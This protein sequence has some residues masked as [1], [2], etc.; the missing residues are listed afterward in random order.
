MHFKLRCKSPKR[1]PKQAQYLDFVRQAIPGTKV[2]AHFV[3]GR[4]C[5]KSTTLILTALRLGLQH[6]P[7]LPGII[8]EPVYPRLDD[9]IVREWQ[10]IV[11][12][13]LYKIN[14]SK[15]FITLI[16]GTIIDLRSRNVD[17]KSKEVS[18]GP[19]YAWALEDEQAYKCDLKK[20]DDVDAA[21]R[22]PK[23]PFLFHGSFST[24]KMNDYHKLCHREEALRIN[25]TSFD[26]PFLPANFAA[27]LESKLSAEYASQE[28][29]GEWISLTGRIWKHWDAVLNRCSDRFDYARPW[30]LWCDLGINSAWIA[31]QK[32]SSGKIVAHFEWTPSDEGAEQTLTRINATM[33]RPPK[34]V[35]VGHDINTRSIVDAQKPSVPFRRLWGSSPE[36]RP[37]TGFIADKQLQHMQG[38]ASICTTHGERMFLIADDFV[39]HDSDKGRGLIEL[40]E[41]DS[42]STTPRTG[43]F[44]PKDHRL[45]HMRDAWMYGII[46]NN[47]PRFNKSNQRAR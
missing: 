47:P 18:K 1:Y 7:G 28:I 16:N 23:A 4:G 13:E 3:G 39:S 37:V 32:N 24:P 29:Y 12:S 9:V 15:M 44:L 35:V 40:F 27:D 2:D 34:R 11:P 8:T 31:V 33:Q 5:A 36:I 30:E 20:W 42:W 6:C 25:A 38:S 41:Q 17:N 21:I 45:E 19:N 14:H 43:E 26:N 46:V 22:H 10:N